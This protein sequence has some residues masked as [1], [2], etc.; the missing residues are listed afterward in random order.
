MSRI[1]T[2]FSAS[3]GLIGGEPFGDCSARN[4]VETTKGISRDST[5]NLTRSSAA[6]GGKSGERLSSS[7]GRGRAGGDYDTPCVAVPS[8]IIILE[9]AEGDGSG[10]QTTLH[11]RLS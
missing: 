9:P 5:P 7:V 3:A 6:I 1:S 8:D 4:A 11:W 2:R 10:R